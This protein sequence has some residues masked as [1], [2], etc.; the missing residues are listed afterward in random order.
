MDSFYNLIGKYDP[1]EFRVENYISPNDKVE[2][3]SLV[4]VTLPDGTEGI[5]VYKTSVYDV[6]DNNTIRI[7][8]PMEQT[9]LVLLP[10]DGR[11]EVCFFSQNGVYKADVRIAD[12]IKINGIY[13]LVAEMLTNLHRYQRREYYRFNCVI[14]M[15]YRVMSQEELE[16]VSSGVISPS[17]DLDE[18]DMKEAMIV[19]ISGGGLRFVAEEQ[20]PIDTV[21]F[22]EFS[23]EIEDEMMP[24]ALA[25]KVIYASEIENREGEYEIRLQ[26][27]Y[28]NNTIREEII[29]FIFEEERKSR[30]K[31]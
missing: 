5:R 16:G 26:Y 15:N 20:Y 11:Y 25:A 19:E 2:I 18:N 3:R 24:F 4:E 6:A 14:E 17:S 9:K 23:L 27:V 8:M 12:R 7:I 10:I 22:V 31:W 28:I 29:K 30:K 1:D 13:I 21:L